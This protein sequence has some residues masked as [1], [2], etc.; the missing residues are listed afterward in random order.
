MEMSKLEKLI[1]EWEQIKDAAITQ[2]KNT[3]AR[4]AE[5]HS[6]YHEQAWEV[7]PREIT[8]KITDIIEQDGVINKLQKYEIKR[9]SLCLICQTG[10]SPT[11]ETIIF[12]NDTIYALITY[13]KDNRTT[14]K[15]VRNWFIIYLIGII[16]IAYSD[17]I[18]QLFINKLIEYLENTIKLA[19]EITKDHLNEAIGE[20]RLCKLGEVS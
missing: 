4:M 3:C 2:L 15:D 6:K 8:I 19:K 14:I 13:R 20:A 17:S 9:I 5:L 11:H 7:I 1:E 10:E 16:F 18:V 12:I